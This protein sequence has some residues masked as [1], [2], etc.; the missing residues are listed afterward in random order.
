MG[1]SNALPLNLGAS[2]VLQYLLLMWELGM[3]L[4]DLYLSHP[5]GQI[6]L[7]IAVVTHL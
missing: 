7:C 3:Q 2:H 1:V 6:S 4:R 5:V